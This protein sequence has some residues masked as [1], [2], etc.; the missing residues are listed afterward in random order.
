MRIRHALFVTIVLWIVSIVAAAAWGY[1]F[2][3]LA[4]FG[5][6]CISW[7]FAWGMTA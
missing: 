4:T 2:F 7:G 1:N 6:G 5:I 3:S